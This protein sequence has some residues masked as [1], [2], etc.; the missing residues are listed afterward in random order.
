MASS[1]FLLD[2]HILVWWL[3]APR[4]L[5]TEQGGVLKR[6]TAGN[7]TVAV[8]AITFVEIAFLLRHGKTRLR[9]PFEKLLRQI[10]ESPVITVLPLTSE[11]ALDVASLIGSLREPAECT[12]VAT[13]RVH[14]L[15]LLTSDQRII[16]S[17]LV[18]VI[19]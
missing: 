12:I 17:K 14:G 10:D 3:T 13:A 9:I 2:T 4:N 5:S 8:C 18:P 16:Q 15:R 19:E 7:E 11:I 6:I 1:R